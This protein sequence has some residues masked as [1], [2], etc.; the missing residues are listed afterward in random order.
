MFGI[1]MPE[2]IVILII[3]FIVVGPKKL[4]GIGQAIGRGIREFRSSLEGR[5]E[6]SNSEQEDTPQTESKGEDKDLS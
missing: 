4:P 6:Y 5:D 2:L 1:G 3:G